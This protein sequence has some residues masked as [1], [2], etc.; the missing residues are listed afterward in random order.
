MG[1]E[2]AWTRLG[3]MQAKEREEGEKG[4]REELDYT[5]QFR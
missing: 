1:E 2:I 5:I 4:M 3:E